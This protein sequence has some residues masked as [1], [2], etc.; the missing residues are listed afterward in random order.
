MGTLLYKDLVV[1]FEF[2]LP[3][4]FAVDEL[5]H[6]SITSLEAECNVIVAFPMLGSTKVSDFP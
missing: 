1:A 6:V 3:V 2:P 5:K 4:C